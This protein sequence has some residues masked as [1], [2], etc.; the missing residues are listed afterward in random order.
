LPRNIYKPRII[1]NLIQHRQRSLRFRQQ[2]VI[3]I[4]F[5]LQQRIINAQ[6]A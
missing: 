6:A 3:Q 5:K 2:F 1:H 4:R